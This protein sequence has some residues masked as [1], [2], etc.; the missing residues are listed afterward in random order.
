MKKNTLLL[1]AIFLICINSYAEEML[2]T[3]NSSKQPKIWL[4]DKKPTGI[5]VDIMNY[6]GKEMGTD[7]RIKLSNWARA[8]KS[9]LS[10]KNGI[11][12]ISMNEERLKFFD[13]SE[14]LYYDKVILVVKR[15]NEFKFEKNEDLT[16]KMIGV[17]RG[18]SFGSEF[19]E[20]K[21]FFKIFEDD[22][23]IQRLRILNGG[24]TDAAVFNPGVAALNLTL[25][26]DSSFSRE[27]FSVLER[28]VN[29]DPNYLAFAKEMNMKGFLSKFNQVLKKGKD[30]GVIQKIIDK[31]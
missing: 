31:Y 5:L 23:N 3:G 8:Y 14:P 13:Y 1:I 10:G 21:K 17:C 18:C 2:I 15:G 29:R 30:T 19:E 7:F 28:P 4:E 20:A 26:E 25:H 11:V 12:G 6:L 24:R 16:G 9:A 22:T 27:Q